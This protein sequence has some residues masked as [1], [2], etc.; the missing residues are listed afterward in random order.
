HSTNDPTLRGLD[1]YVG[2]VG[3]YA[4]TSTNNGLIEAPRADV[5]IAGKTV[6]QFGFIDSSTSVA[7]NGRIDLLADYNAIPNTNKTQPNPPPFLFTST[8][9][10]SFGSDSVTQIVPE[11]S[12]ADRVVGTRL[13]LNSTI[14]VE[15]LAIHSESNSIL[16]A[17]SAAA[18]PDATKPTLAIGGR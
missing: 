10:V 7:L 1:V 9:L 17:P 4:G 5:T 8:G 15:G 3:S 18:S 16:F 6:D 13:A 2:Q 14:F 11:Y 12:S